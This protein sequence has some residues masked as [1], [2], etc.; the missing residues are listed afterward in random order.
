MKLSSGSA[1]E[2]HIAACFRDE[3]APRRSS[4][5]DVPPEC[6]RFHLG[7]RIIQSNTDTK[8]GFETKFCE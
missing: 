5:D 7:L 4:Q 1:R 3:A 2:M 8:S 6:A